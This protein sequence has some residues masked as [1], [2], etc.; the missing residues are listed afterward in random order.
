MVLTVCKI[1]LLLNSLD[2]LVLDLKT[3]VE[4]LQGRNRYLDLTKVSMKPLDSLLQR[5]VRPLKEC[6]RVGKEA[7]LLLAELAAAYLSDHL[8]L[9][10][11]LDSYFDEINDRSVRKFH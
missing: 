6:L 4:S 1:Y 2:E 5:S 3:F 10:D 11:S 9:F 8:V 7:Y